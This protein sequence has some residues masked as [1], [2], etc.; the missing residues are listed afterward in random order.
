MPYQHG[1]SIIKIAFADD[2]QLLQEIIPKIIDGFENCK[3][4]M[5]AANGKELLAK[6]QNNSSV[7]LVLLDIKMPELDGVDTAKKIKQEF[8][9]I[10]VLFFSQYCN[11]L[12]YKRIIAAKADGF[13]SKDCLPSDIRKAIYTVMKAGYYIHGGFPAFFKEEL[14]G[15]S[16]SHANNNE[17]A[18]TDEE[19]EF[20]RLAATNMTYVAIAKQMKTSPRHI[21]YIREGLFQKFEIRS[22]VELAMFAWKGGIA[23]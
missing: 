10:R 18:I 20:L 23:Q 4:V 22:R 15:K 21:D 13:I 6:L 12:V 1:K 11:E 9:G 17:L 8:P 2:N 7:N 5:V 14:N 16:I 3:V 19:I